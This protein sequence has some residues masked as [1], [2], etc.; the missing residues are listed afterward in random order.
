MTTTERKPMPLIGRDICIRVTDKEGH[1]TH[2]Q[3]RVWD[4]DLYFASLL[5]REC[6][7]ERITRAEYQ[8]RL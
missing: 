6:T 5:E 7:Y 4:A 3:V 2:L 1:V 8:A